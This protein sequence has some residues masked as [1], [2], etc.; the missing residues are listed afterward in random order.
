MEKPEIFVSKPLI[1]IVGGPGIGKTRLSATAPDGFCLDIEDG[2]AS[3]F[4]PNRV[5][6]FEV[7]ENILVQLN[8]HLTAFKSLPYD[9]ETRTLDKQ[10][11]PVKYVT[12][13]SL[14]A[15]QQIHKYMKLKNEFSAYDARAAWGKLL[16]AMVP[17]VYLMQSVPVPVVVISHVHSV[18]PVYKGENVRKYGW[19]GLAFQGQLED[20][21]M[22]WFSYVLHLTMGEDGKRKCYTQPVIYQD[23][24]L[25]A[26][27]RNGLFP[28]TS[29]EIKADENGYPETKAI[30]TIFE[31]HTW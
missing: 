14:D 9:K 25:S 21:I 27:D 23:Y 15:I 4:P 28:R 19:K 16:D 11:L 18:E 22:R 3:A 30:T 6:K 13:D 8:D 10:G 7:N 29:F 24:V 2:A 12:V 31:R 20:Q 1:G 17:T 5:Q 26:K